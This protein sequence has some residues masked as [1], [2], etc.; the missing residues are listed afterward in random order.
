MEDGTQAT[1]ETQ[2][3]ETNKSTEDDKKVSKT[4][5]QIL[6]EEN[7]SLEFEL[8]RKQTIRNEALLAGTTGGNVV[9]KEPEKIS[10]TEY[11]DKFMKG[12]V[13]PMA[14]DDISIN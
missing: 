10:D 12:E 1:T 6:K 13:N 4:D 9:A 8:K 5:S 7:D 3:T 11:A 14:E 2:A